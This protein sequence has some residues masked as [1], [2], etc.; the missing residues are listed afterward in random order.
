[1]ADK[2]AVSSDDLLACLRNKYRGRGY[3]VLE[4]VR[5]DAGFGA[6]STVDAVVVSTWP[7]H[8]LWRSAFELKVSRGDFLREVNRPGKNGW[9]K[10]MF[11]FFWFVAPR[12]IVS[13]EELPAGAGLMV[14]RGETLEVVRQAGQ[15]AEPEMTDGLLAMLVRSVV[16]AG[17]GLRQAGYL[18][19]REKDGE[20]Q[21]ARAWSEA[22]RVFLT[23][24]G[25]DRSFHD[26]WEAERMLAAL[27][28]AAGN[29]DADSVA[30]ENRKVLD[31]FR[32]RIGE[33][34]RTYMALAAVTLDEVDEAGRRLLPSVEYGLPDDLVRERTRR[35]Y[36][37]ADEKESRKALKLMYDR[38][39]RRPKR[40]PESA[41]GD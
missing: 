25:R 18:A 22:A 28:K 36:V 38:L 1:M 34:L 12:G 31:E 10:R 39:E 2:P 20:W 14:P 37:S 6:D 8:G 26:E 5:N 23:R 35:R 17:E 21:K 13:P 7:S 4:Q 24:H 19:R 27:E 41:P 11:H 29:D 15:V 40:S 9:A 30:R 16:D 3:I 32:V 33:M